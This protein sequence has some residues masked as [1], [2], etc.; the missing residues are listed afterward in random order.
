[1]TPDPLSAYCT[2]LGSR[3]LSHAGS[4][5]LLTVPHKAFSFCR[6][7]YVMSI[8]NIHYPTV[9][10]LIHNELE[11]IWKGAVLAE[12]LFR[13]TPDA[14][15]KTTRKLSQQAVSLRRCEHSISWINTYSFITIT[16][17]HW[18]ALVL[19][20]WEFWSSDLGTG[21]G[22]FSRQSPDPNQFPGQKCITPYSS[23]FNLH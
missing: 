17:L 21:T 1:M 7:L 5:P 16:P 3:Q 6:V 18:F 14:P 11:G 22:S 4:A 23:Q 19:C 8:Y 2:H 13:H 12:V 15:R 9:Q 10:L 20:M